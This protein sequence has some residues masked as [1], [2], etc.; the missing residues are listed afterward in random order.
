MNNKEVFR[1]LHPLA[2]LLV[3]SHENVFDLLGQIKFA[4]MQR[5][6]KAFGDFIEV[7]AASDDVPTRGNFQF[8]HERNKT[9]QD[10]RHSAAYRGRVHHLYGLAT[11]MAGQ[12]ADL[13]KLWLAD[14]GLIICKAGRGRGRWL[15]SFDERVLAPLNK[16]SGQIGLP[17]AALR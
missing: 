10:F 12:K 17:E 3:V 9:I 7:I 14:D 8:A 1:K 13:V 6:V 11:Q 5:V 2:V 16:V 4:A 15:F